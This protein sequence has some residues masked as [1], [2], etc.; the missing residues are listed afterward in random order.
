MELIYRDIGAVLMRSLIRPALL[1]SALLG[2]AAC[3]QSGENAKQNFSDAGNGIGNSATDIGHGF[4]QGA[5]ATGQ[6][7]TQG[8]NE[9]GHAITSTA[10]QVGQS[11]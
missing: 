4:S 2:L 6:A 8:A 7:I 9:T 10:H 5:N 11:F 1:F 3:N